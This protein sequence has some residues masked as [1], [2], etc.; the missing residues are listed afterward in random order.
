MKVAFLGASFATGLCAE[1]RYCFRVN[2]E[3][4]EEQSR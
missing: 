2:F 4:D 1:L 3:A